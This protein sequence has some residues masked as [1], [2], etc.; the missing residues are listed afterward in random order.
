MLGIFFLD[1]YFRNREINISQLSYI[2]DALSV[3]PDTSPHALTTEVLLCPPPFHQSASSTPPFI[4]RCSIFNM[5]QKEFPIPYTSCFPILA[6]SDWNDRTMTVGSRVL[7]IVT[8][9]IKS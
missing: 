3:N 7:S 1:I 9:E 6:C 5:N 4:N 2:S 8:A